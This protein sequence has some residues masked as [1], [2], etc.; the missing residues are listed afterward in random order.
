MKIIYQESQCFQNVVK[1][2]HEHADNGV[3][4]VSGM[5][6][7]QVKQFKLDKQL[8][9]VIHFRLYEHYHDFADPDI[10][11]EKFLAASFTREQAIRKAIALFDDHLGKHGLAHEE[12]NLHPDW[13]PNP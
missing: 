4:L 7:V 2:W 6:E 12:A 13:V 11:T 3:V 5:Q 1:A 8:R 10:D 9:Y